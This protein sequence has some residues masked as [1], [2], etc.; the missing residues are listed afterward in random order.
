VRASRSEESLLLEVCDTGPGFG[1]AKA[2]NGTRGLG[3]ETTR[4]RLEQLYGS[5]QRLECVDLEDG[6]AAVRISMPLRVPPDASP[7]AESMES[8]LASKG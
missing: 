5:K 2:H 1:L 7:P 8:T 3:L 4:A 6:G